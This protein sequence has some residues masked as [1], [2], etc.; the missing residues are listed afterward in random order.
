MKIKNIYDNEG[1]SF[2]RYTVVLDQREN[3]YNW[4]LCLSHNPTSIQGF[5]QFGECIDGDILLGKKINLEDLPK[6]IQNHI[7][8]R[9]K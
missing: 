9:I 7:A 4:C 8:K 5:S 3:G 1:K 2:D 6:E